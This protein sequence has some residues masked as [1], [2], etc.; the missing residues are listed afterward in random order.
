MRG[1][2]SE[3]DKQSIKFEII[4]S[5][6]FLIV[7]AVL[8]IFFSYLFSAII[9]TIVLTVIY[10]VSA[11][12]IKRK[13]DISFLNILWIQAGLNWFTLPGLLLPGAILVLLPGGGG[14]SIVL[15][16]SAY[17]EAVIPPIAISSLIYAAISKAKKISSSEA[18]TDMMKKKASGGF[19]CLSAAF[20]ALNIISLIIY[21]L[22]L[23]RVS[24]KYYPDKKAIIASAILAVIYIASA[25]MIKIKAGLP[26]HKII[27]AQLGGFFTLGYFV[28]P[29]LFG[30]LFTIRMYIMWLFALISHGMDSLYWYCM[31]VIPA[32]AV[33]EIIMFLIPV[34][35]RK[36]E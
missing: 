22:I 15:Y 29:L 27:F 14:L 7:N 4:S 19:I 35:S 1:A 28:F 34:R 23:G 25:L 5:I 33:S 36:D 6:V 9:N 18:E 30:A 32:L 26:S 17:L 2:I 10:V 20:F 13:S 31:L 24:I 16:V 3:N 11:L 8:S 21:S 12:V